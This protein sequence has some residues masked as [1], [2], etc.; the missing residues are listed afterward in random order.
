[1]MPD[2]SALRT[3]ASITFESVSPPGNL[4]HESFVLNLTLNDN[5]SLR[6][7]AY[8]VLPLVEGSI[9]S[10]SYPSNAIAQSLHEKPTRFRTVTRRTK[11][12]LVRTYD[13]SYA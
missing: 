9:F 4:S 5:T 1:M 12:P 8:V 11:K 10:I 7:K 6:L 13:V 3:T 2:A